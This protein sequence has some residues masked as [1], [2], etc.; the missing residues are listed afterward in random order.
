MKFLHVQLQHDLALFRSFNGSYSLESIWQHFSSNPPK[1]FE[2]YYKPPDAAAKNK[3]ENDTEQSPQNT[4]KAV[5][6]S[7]SPSQSS[8]ES[9]TRP[10]SSDWNLGIFGQSESKKSSGSGGRPIGGQD[11]DKEKWVLLGAFG[12]VVLI[13]TL[14]FMEVNYREIGWK[15]FVSRFVDNICI[16]ARN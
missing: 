1:G 15:E 5:P 7:T 16:L 12:A 8:G 3:K 6:P 2:K 11:G 10:S 13:G 9:K 4:K 14:V